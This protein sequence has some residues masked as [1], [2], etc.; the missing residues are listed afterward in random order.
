MESY[1]TQPDPFLSQFFAHV[2]LEMRDSF[3]DEQLEAIKIAFEPPLK[4]SHLVD[5]RFSVPIPF[6]RFYLVFLVGRET[7]SRS[8]LR[9]E[10][11]AWRQVKRF[12]LRHVFIP[13]FLA[14]IPEGTAATFTEA[15]LAI[16]QAVF[17]NRIW[18]KHSVD[19]RL[20]LPFGNSG[21]YFVLLMGREQRSRDRLRRE[22]LQYRLIGFLKR[23]AIALSLLLLAIAVSLGGFILF[24][25]D[26]NI[27]IDPRTEMGKEDGIAH[28]IDDF[29][30]KFGIY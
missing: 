17:A 1:R 27:I 25:G 2:P 26:N 30:R 28:K 29:L 18:R 9:A 16:V 12:G 13:I 10:R 8:R 20:S 21:V 3:T 7:R 5:W 23:V 6:L 14:R 19:V 15:Q 22:R 11:K 4:S 24:Q